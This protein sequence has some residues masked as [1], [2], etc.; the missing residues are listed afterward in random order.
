MSKKANTTAI[1]LFVIGAVILAMAGVVIFG[2]GKFFTKKYHYVAYFSGSVKGLS[3]G[4]PVLWKGVKVGEVTKISMEFDARE[5]AMRIAVIFQMTRGNS[6]VINSEYYEG[7]TKATQDEIMIDLV[8]RGLRAQLAP[9]SVITGMLYVKLDFF[10]ETKGTL[11]AAETLGSDI[12]LTEIPTIPSDMEELART[13]ENLPLQQ[14]AQNLEDMTAGIDQLVNSPHIAAILTSV[15]AATATL[16]Q[17][18]INLDKQ[19]VSLAGDLKIVIRNT[20][21]LVRNLNQQVDP[22]AQGL[23]DTTDAATGAFNQAEE[24]LSLTQ[25]PAA[26]LVAD[27]QQAM[28]AATQALE[29]A[30][31]TMQA[32]DTLAGEDSETI[33]TLNTALEEIAM[34]ARSIRAVAEYLERHPESLLRGKGG[35]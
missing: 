25:G 33:Y 26:E 3:V 5:M 14:I 16:D 30:N 21:R 9:Q 4:A 1:G 22:V 32:I 7:I 35:K 18:M 29:Q 27:I 15:E 13:F 20:N 34:A 8:N 24:V 11:Y 31:T 28:D 12:E 17:T 6:K 23:I 19:L 2:G 10:P